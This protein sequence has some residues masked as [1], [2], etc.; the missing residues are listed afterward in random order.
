MLDFFFKITHTAVSLGAA[1]QLSFWQITQLWG[2]HK[3]GQ[4]LV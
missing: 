3:L 4:N 1:E 2:I